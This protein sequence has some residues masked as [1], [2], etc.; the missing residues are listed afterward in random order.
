M[1]SW[2]GRGAAAH[3]RIAPSRLAIEQVHPIHLDRSML[4]P[5][6]IRCGAPNTVVC[7][8]IPLKVRR[9][10]ANVV[11]Q[12]IIGGTGV[13]ITYSEAVVRPSQSLEDFPPTGKADVHTLLGCK[14]IRSRCLDLQLAKWTGLNMFVGRQMSLGCVA[15]ERPAFH[16]LKMEVSCNGWQQ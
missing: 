3:R 2:V 5:M 8:R 10:H 1:T 14:P 12:A 7:R 4:D 11:G 16:Q 9:K 15:V 6:F 13:H